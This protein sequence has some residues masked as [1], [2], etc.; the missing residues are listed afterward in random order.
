MGL[1]GDGETRRLLD[2]DTAVD[3]GL[4]A[5][6]KRVDGAFQLAEIGGDRH[7]VD[8]AVADDD[9]AA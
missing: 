3:L 4:A 9:G 5:G 6:E 2:H 1:S 8:L 7:V